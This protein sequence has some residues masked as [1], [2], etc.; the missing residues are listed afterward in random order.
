MHVLTSID[1]LRAL[2]HAWRAEG[3]TVGF[4][5]TMGN[6]HDGHLSLLD[7][8]RSRCDRTLC[9][10]YVNPLQ[11]DRA[12]D[13]D[14]YPRTLEE[15]LDS[16]QS[17]GADAVFVPDDAMIYPRGM[18]HATTVDVPGITDI[19]EGAHRRGHFVGVATVVCKLFNLV[20][21]DV[22]VFGEKDFQQLLVVKRMAAD[23]NL[24][25]DVVGAPTARDAHGLALSSRN[26]YLTDAERG[27]A[28][29]LYREMHACARA[30]LSGESDVSGLERR[31]T[32]ALA[33]AGFKPDYFTVRSTLDLESPHADERPLDWVIL[34]AAQ[35]GKARLI[36]NL[37]VSAAQNPGD[38]P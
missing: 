35:L 34:V 36:D 2:R 13:L 29:Q 18:A 5:P 1:D 37:R 9:S 14:R 12:G 19:L 6:L 38:P 28:A 27:L 7:L 30:L 25:V 17:L 16:L 32:R 8:A 23:L 3:Q 22:A 20:Q 15:D 4:V 26:G 10:I 11:F 24:P 21:P 31:H 33:D